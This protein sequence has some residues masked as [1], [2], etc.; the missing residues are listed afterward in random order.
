MVQS[1]VF[2][3]VG[4]GVHKIVV[5]TNVAETSITIDDV[6]TVIDSGRVKEMRCVCRP[7]HSLLLYQLLYHGTHCLLVWIILFSLHVCAWA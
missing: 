2:E 1:K 3:R 7:S 5:A 4:R 6:T